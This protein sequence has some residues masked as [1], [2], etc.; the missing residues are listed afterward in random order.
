M[1]DV[2]SAA[3]VFIGPTYLLLPSRGFAAVN[4][5]L[6]FS[7]HWRGVSGATIRR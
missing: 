1:G 6:A 3:L 4:A 7:W 5:V 2:L